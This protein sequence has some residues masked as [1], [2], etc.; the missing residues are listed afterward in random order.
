M[1]IE[2]RPITLDNF[3]AI[4]QLVVSPEQ[5]TQVDSNAISLA[6][7][8]FMPFA[9]FRAIYA[10]N[11][12]VGFILVD[13]DTT[14]GKFSLWRLML[15]QSQQGKG[16]GRLAI[17]ALTNALQREFGISELFTS[18]VTGEN[19]PIAFYQS[20]GFELTGALVAGREIELCL[21]IEF[22]K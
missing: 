6:E 5:V 21:P 3:Y 7:A 22:V 13:A 1:N 2:L 14:T 20:C 9:W 19:S 4:C 12:P 11:Q 17:S 8:N 16:Y 10:N 15:D 18:V